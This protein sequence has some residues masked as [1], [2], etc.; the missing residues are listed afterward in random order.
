[1]E[2]TCVKDVNIARIHPIYFSHI[3]GVREIGRAHV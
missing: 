1:M 2:S 3:I